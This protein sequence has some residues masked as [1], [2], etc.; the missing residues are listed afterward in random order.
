MSELKKNI[1]SLVLAMIL[2]VSLVVEEYGPLIAILTL[3][4]VFALLS[5]LGKGIVL[6][7]T[8][9]LFYVVTCLI[10]PMIGYNLYQAD[11]KLSKLW[12][13]YMQV[14]ESV[15][16]S[17]AFPGITLF[18]FALTLPIS[19]N[20]DSGRQITLTMQRIRLTLEDER[21]RNIGLG[22]LIAGLLV[23]LA[24]PYLPGGLQ[25]FANLIYYS[26]FSGLLYVYFSRNFRYRM[27]II[28]LFSLSIFANALKLGMF[29]IV[30]YMSI[31]VYSI[32][33]LGNKASLMKKSLFFFGAIAFLIVLQNAKGTYR[34]YIWMSEYSDNKAL[35]F[36]SIF[37][38][39]I[40]KGDALIE[41]K[42]FFPIYLRG[43][44]GFNVSLVMKRMP[45]LKPYDDGARLTTVVLSAFVP[46]FLW[47]DKPEAGGKFNMF[48]YAGRTIRGMSVN[49]GPLGEAYGSF[50]VLGGC[51]YMFLLGLFIRWVYALLFKIARTMPLIVCWIPVVFFQVTY[52]AETD[53][54][55]ILNS[56]LKA[57][58]YVW[59]VYKAYPAAFG[60][61]S[62]F[63]R[64]YVKSQVVSA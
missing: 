64:S 31:T 42:A 22:I 3:A 4:L 60:L 24:T 36:T 33:F 28:L 44:Q 26:S 23:S 9:A 13:G 57:G 15:Y 50:G 53:T 38:E 62:R 58:F 6:R 61:Y 8:V 39:N 46:R 29:T 40:Q 63:H 7:E 32:L 14:P 10:M 27:L 5:K 19:G 16:F 12:V 51:I 34:K 55:A 47:P 30:A 11:N 25:F 49:V 54:L 21:N 18:C 17:Y 56:I 52:S 59:L 45:S 43:N 1:L 20:A 48:Y 2:L 35:L 37:V 41:K